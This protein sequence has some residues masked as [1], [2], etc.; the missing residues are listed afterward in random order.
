MYVGFSGIRTRII[1]EKGKHADH[2]S[3]TKTTRPSF[4]RSKSP[5]NFSRIH[6]LTFVV[7]VTL[8]VERVFQYLTKLEKFLKAK[9][10]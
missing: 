5:A 1:R 7:K 2:C 10:I 3:T 4:D 6:G 9:K 8:S